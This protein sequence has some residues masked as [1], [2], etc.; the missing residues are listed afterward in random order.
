MDRGLKSIH[1][2]VL[3]TPNKVRIGFKIS[4]F[5]LFTHDSDFDFDSEQTPSPHPVP[6]EAACDPAGGPRGARGI[7]GQQ[8]A[9]ADPRGGGGHAVQPQGRP[10][11]AAPAIDLH[12]QEKESLTTNPHTHSG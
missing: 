11:Q 10:T 1:I 3:K 4:F 8:R 6:R 9:G 12:V 7:P 2:S 5:H